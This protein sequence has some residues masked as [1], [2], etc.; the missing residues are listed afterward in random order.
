MLILRKYSSLEQ[1]EFARRDYDGLNEAGKEALRQR[2]NDYARVLKANYRNTMR[3]IGRA[4]DPGISSL[5]TN[6]VTRIGGIESTVNA[7]TSRGSSD[8]VENFIKT[9]KN[10]TTDEMLKGSAAAKDIMRKETLANKSYVT[11]K[12]VAEN[13][14]DI[15]LI[16]LKANPKAVTKNSGKLLKRA[17]IGGAAVLGTAGLAYAGKKLYDKKKQK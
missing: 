8:S 4:V 15:K 10:T 1:R 7:K 5:E 9:H 11:P 2:R 17:G 12:E 16:K 6:L 3:D 14:R 13:A